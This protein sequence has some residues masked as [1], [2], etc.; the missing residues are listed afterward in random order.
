MAYDADK[1]QIDALK[2]WWKE[3]GRVAIAGVVMGLGCVF[4]WNAWQSH[5]VK[6]AESASQ[7]Y[8]QII[9]WAAQRHYQRVDELAESLLTEHPASG[10]APMSALIRAHSAVAQGRPQEAEGFL[11]WVVDNADQTY[12]TVIARLRLARL[13]ADRQDY[14]AATGHLDAADPGE[15]QTSF[16]ELRGDIL[17]AQNQ[18]EE[19]FDHYQNVL[20]SQTLS[21]SARQRVQMKAD[22]LGMQADRGAGL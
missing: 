17:V 4:G 5:T 1:E 14:S 9:D 8:E 12:L 13:A 18:P 20:D 2:A 22:D 3:N 10:Y 7:I 15:L 16:E 19:A 21:A 6:Q 11:Q